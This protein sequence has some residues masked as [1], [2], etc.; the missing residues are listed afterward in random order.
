GDQAP[1]EWSP[2]EGG[3][4]HAGL[5]PAQRQPQIRLPDRNSERVTLR[6]EPGR[7]LLLML[8]RRGRV[9]RFVAAGSCGASPDGRSAQSA[10][11]R[12]VCGSVDQQFPIASSIQRSGADQ[13]FMTRMVY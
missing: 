2:A 4:V 5:V 6:L 10:K 8:A 11:L 12:A 9:W 13:E 3:G 1:A 7:R